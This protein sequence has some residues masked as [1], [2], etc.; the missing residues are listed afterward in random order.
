MVTFTDVED[1]PIQ[2]PFDRKASAEQQIAKN[3][4]KR[5]FDLLVAITATI[6]LLSWLIPLLG[7]LIVL[8]SPG[9]VLFVQWRTGRNGRMFRCLKF[10]TMRVDHN[11]VTFRQ[12]AHN[13]SRVTPIGRWLRRTNLDEMPQFL[14]VLLGSMS[15]VGPRP[16]AIQHDAEFWFSLPAYPKR[17]EV[18]PGITGL[19]QVRG[20][21]GIIDHGIKME[22]RLRY[23]LFYIRKHSFWL[24][25]QTCWWTVQKM[26]KGDS[27]AW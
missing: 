13:D 18:T 11:N 4:W 2:L 10:R 9:P 22:H 25:I 5:P 1:I 6:L 27:N 7:L 21:R 16:H 12:T 17:Y 19:A 3:A 8:T 14:N 23:D 15:V 26:F 20:A 24:D